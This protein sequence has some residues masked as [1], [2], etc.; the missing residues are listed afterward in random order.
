MGTTRAGEVYHWPAGHIA[1]TD[2]GM[3]FLAITPVAQEREMEEHLAG[4]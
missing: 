3:V 1:W 2:E 4:S